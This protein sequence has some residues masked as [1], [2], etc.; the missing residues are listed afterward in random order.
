MKA[1]LSICT[2]ILLLLHEVA[3]HEEH[4]VGSKA[5]QQSSVKYDVLSVSLNIPQLAIRYAEYAVGSQRRQ[6]TGRDNSRP[7]EF[8]AL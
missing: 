3:L 1:A 4:D 6:T 5:I 2:L 7:L 8:V